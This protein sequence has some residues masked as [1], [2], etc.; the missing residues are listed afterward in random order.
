MITYKGTLK[1]IL[2]QEIPKD[3][4]KQG[5]TAEKK[6]GGVVIPG[7]PYYWLPVHRIKEVLN[8]IGDWEIEHTQVITTQNTMTVLL[9]LKVLDKVVYGGASKPIGTGE[10]TF[11]LVEA[12]AI[13]NAAAKL[14]RL[15]GSE[16]NND[17]DEPETV[18]SELQMLSELFEAKKQFLNADKIKD[19]NRIIDSKDVSSYSKL[20][21]LL[22]D[23]GVPE[24]KK[25]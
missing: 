18:K 15:L 10:A 21:K 16:L 13:K 23:L 14:G 25:Y 3:W 24:V 5:I 4:I 6:V 19:A 20:F 8:N 12:F 7:K 9:K 2:S 11:Q 1:Q 22:N 17:I